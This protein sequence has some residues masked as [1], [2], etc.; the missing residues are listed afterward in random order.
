MQPATAW[1]AGS[2]LA[3]LK[4]F[5]DYALSKPD[6]YLVTMRQL[7]GELG[8]RCTHWHCCFLSSGSNMN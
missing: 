8:Y 1:Q 3:D 5:V 4:R 6:T 7:I 2:N